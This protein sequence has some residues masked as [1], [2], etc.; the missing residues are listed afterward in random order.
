MSPKTGTEKGIAVFAP[1]AGGFWVG[2]V[3]TGVDE[4]CARR[5][6]PLTV[7]QTA[8]G[9]QASVSDRFPVYDY[10]RLARNHR[11]GMLV[12]TS[13]AH[14]LAALSRIREPMIA[15]DGPHP[16]PGEPT[17][18]LD[19]AGGAAQAVG[20]L[21]EHGHR[22]IGFVGAFVQHDVMERYRG[23]LAAL[24]AAGI[25]P[26]E[27]LVYGVPTDLS[28][29][30]REAAAAILEA[31][32]P[33][34][35]VFAS[36]DTH[37]VDLIEAL[38]EAGVRV[39]EDVAVIG[40]DDSEIAQ[41][42]VPALTSVR[43]IPSVLG[44]EAANVLLDFVDG[45]PGADGKHVVS[46]KLILRHS[47]GCFDRPHDFVDAAVDW[48]AP[49]WQDRLRDMLESALAA[50]PEL[51]SADHAGMHW[52]GVE[53]VVRAFDAAVRGL[54]PSHVTELDEAWRG[55]S[56]HT[57][58]AE[59]LLGL[60]DL[61][62]FVGLCRQGSAHGDPDA[63]RLRLRGFLAQARLQIVR[64]TAVADPLRHQ[65]APKTVREMTRSFLDP[66]PKGSTNLEW[67]KY[68]NATRGC[69]ALW[70]PGKGERSLRIAGLYGENTGGL[71]LGAIVAPEDFPPVGWHDGD[72]RTVTI[73]PIVAPNC[74]WGILAVVL[75]CEHRYF[76]GFWALQYGTSY[77]ALV[78]AHA[79]EESANVVSG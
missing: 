49:D 35:A 30:G 54:P 64:Y 75:P 59:T 78:L 45:V 25:E 41:T 47:C 1:E 24:E 42:A 19:N 18:V 77:L 14:E 4:V 44:S 74:D 43:Q 2:D 60:V 3:M 33:L 53:T 76:D 37:A 61:L 12:I 40:F 21:V 7:I 48:N 23:Y 71:E 29:G 22:K 55:A 20:H 56:R 10:Y 79:A 67:L 34:T 50:Y 51:T 5:G 65:Q 57:R 72:A 36:T 62:E 15:I 26:D 27:T 63:V 52:T 46:T 6:I 16:R 11:L 58:N 28:A 66:S 8:V 38:S 31:G 68:V 70:E 39:P 32:V 9:W 73:V 13:T 69:V 17:V